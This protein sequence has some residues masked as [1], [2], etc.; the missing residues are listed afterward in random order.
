MK[1]KIENYKKL[2]CVY[3]IKD[4][5]TQ[6]VYIGSTSNLLCRLANHISAFKKGCRACSSSK[7]LENDSYTFEVLRDGLNDGDVK[8]SER[9]FILAYSDRCVN[10]NI[11]IV[12]TM[13]EYRKQ[14]YKKN[15][16]MMVYDSTMND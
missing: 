9:S 6:K 4:T 11:P 12:M 7:I 8:E 5:I 10:I 2:Y 14:Y 13:P 1:I 15:K 16:P 3:M